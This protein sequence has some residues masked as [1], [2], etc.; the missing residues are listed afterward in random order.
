QVDHVGDEENLGDERVL[1]DLVAGL[2]V[3]LLDDPGDARLQGD[4]APRH[5]RARGDRFLHDRRHAR[6]HG[7]VRRGLRLRLLIKEGERASE[8]Q[9]N[10]EQQR[11][12]EDSA[13]HSALNAS[14]GWMRAAW[15]AGITAARKPPSNKT[16][17]APSTTLRS[18]S[19]SESGA[20]G[21]LAVTRLATSRS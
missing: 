13:D 6:L 5:D 11:K 8:S 12:R 17:P 7:L 3:K 19:G 1:A 15:R 2:D 20:C 16:K 21:M 18:T 4:L 9:E 14:T 10:A